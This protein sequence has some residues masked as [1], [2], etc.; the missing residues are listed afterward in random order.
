MSRSH[1]RL[2]YSSD[3]SHMSR[4]KKCEEIPCVCI[5]EVDVRPDETTL[6]IRLEKKGRGGKVVTVVFDLPFNEKYFKDLSKKIKNHCGSGGSFKGGIM[7]FQGDQKERVKIFLEKLG[8]TVK[9]SGG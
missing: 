5:K 6:K 8:F 9:F 3:G 4:C 7:E 2:V 1:S